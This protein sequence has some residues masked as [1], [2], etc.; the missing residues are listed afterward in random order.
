MSAKGYIVRYGLTGD[1]RCDAQAFDSHEDADAFVELWTSAN[2][3]HF[4]AEVKS[5]RQILR[6]RP[7]S[8]ATK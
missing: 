2:P 7:R 3:A 5:Q 1:R 8:E 6:H 4:W